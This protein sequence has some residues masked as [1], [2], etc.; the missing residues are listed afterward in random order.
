MNSFYL[1]AVGWIISLL[2][3]YKDSLGIKYPKKIDMLLNK[4]K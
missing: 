1:L 4:K 2:F 3:F